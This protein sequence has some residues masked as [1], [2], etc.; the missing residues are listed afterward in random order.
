[1][2][3]LAHLS[4]LHLAAPLKRKDLNAK[5]AL[6]Y[7]NWHFRRRHEFKPEFLAQAVESLLEK[8]PDAVLL[9]GDLT[10]HG[11]AEEF[12]LAEK[13]LEPLTRAG[14]PVLAV[15]GN[16]DYYGWDEETA[17]V[18]AAVQQRLRLD[19]EVD[20]ANVA[21]LGGY[22]I[23]LLEQACQTPLF[24][25]YGQVRE[26]IKQTLRPDAKGRIAVGHYPL[27]RADG[28][29]LPFF[30][31]LRGNEVL[32]RFFSEINLSAYLCGHIHFGLTCPI[33]PSLPQIAAGSIDKIINP[34]LY[35]LNAKGFARL[36]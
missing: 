25:S 1:M 3:K 34:P 4:D 27:V 8:K 22:E 35:T 15:A 36:P 14:I 10:Q 16:H 23:L 24:C 32:T 29:P 2:L 31:G 12:L 11:L 21:R 9:S 6:G 7:L 19:V 33:S 20:E 13:M 28:K 26:L 17:A 30:C 5:R 18:F